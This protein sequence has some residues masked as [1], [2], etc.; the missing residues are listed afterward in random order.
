M[1]EFILDRDETL[2]HVTAHEMAHIRLERLKRRN[3]NAAANNEMNADA[4]ARA[5]TLE[6]K[7]L[8]AHQQS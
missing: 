8:V 2:V 1:S 3:P 7:R 6:F 4:I 5:V